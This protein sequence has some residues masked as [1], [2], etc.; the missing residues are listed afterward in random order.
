MTHNLKKKNSGIVNS[1][2]TSMQKK[3]TIMTKQA[4]FTRFNAATDLGCQHKRK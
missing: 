4:T 3:S 1:T 2:K